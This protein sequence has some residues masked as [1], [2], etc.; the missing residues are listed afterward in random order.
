MSIARC[1]KSD[2]K[3]DL[4]I[5]NCI[6]INRSSLWN[7]Q[8]DGVFLL[9]KWQNIIN[10]TVCPRSL[11]HFYIVNG[12]IG[13]DKTSLTTSIIETMY[14]YNYAVVPA[15]KKD[16]MP[17]LILY[18]CLTAG[19]WDLGWEIFNF[20]LNCLLFLN[21]ITSPRHCRTN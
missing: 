4:N 11:L 1:Q 10:H 6:E 12:Y 20:S 3:T 2:K 5:K 9:W 14:G 17:F 19:S 8:D 7:F 21:S 15:E 16:I 18:F 13:M